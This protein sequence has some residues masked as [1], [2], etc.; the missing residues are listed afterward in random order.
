MRILSDKVLI[1]KYT[2][3]KVDQ[4]SGMEWGTDGDS[5]PRAEVILVSDDVS[6]IV[7]PGDHVHYIEP[8]ERGRCEYNGEEH[9]II[10]VANL[11]AI[12]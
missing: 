2:T 12:L 11:V 1:K 3:K 5:L 10:P 9:F 6:H 7:S 8:R 4:Q